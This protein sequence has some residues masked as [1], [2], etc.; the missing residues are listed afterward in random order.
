MAGNEILQAPSPPSME[1]GTVLLE[2][3]RLILRRYFLSDA[4]AM[5]DLANDRDVTVQ[6]RT[7]PYPYTLSHAESFLKMIVTPDEA[8][9]AQDCGIFLKPNTPGNPSDKE[10]FIGG[11]GANPLT[12]VHY[13][14][15]EMG[16]W[17]GKPAWG[18]GYATE[19]LKGFVRWVFATW[20]GLNR[21]QAATY[22]ENSGS[23]NVLKKCGFL[24]EGRKREAV[25][26]N[27]KVM[28][29]VWFGLLRSELKED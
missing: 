7:F 9:Y 22:S 27:G 10:Q 15:W 20:P 16:Y 3:E 18:Q 5:A 13:R 14:T 21:L 1:P 12:D 24:E 19:A 8:I 11:M 17:L 29:E 4:P 25:E 23:Q 6:L 2:T 26:K 28:D